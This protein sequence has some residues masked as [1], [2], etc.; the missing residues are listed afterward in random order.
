MS[1]KKDE[2]VIGKVTGVESYG[3]FITFDDGYTGLVHISE[4]SDGFVDDV[5]DYFEVGD[6]V[7]VK[8]VSVD[9]KNKRLTLTV[10]YRNNS[11]DKPK[12]EEVGE[13]FKP[14]KN[15]LDSWIE[16]KLEDI[17]AENSKKE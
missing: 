1:Y 17:N 7:E 15:N 8:V 9:K 10:K 3:A 4:I 16:A 2:L 12:I 13:G 6:D 11:N 5:L 14:L